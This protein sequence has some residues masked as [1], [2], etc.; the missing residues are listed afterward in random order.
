MIK[1]LF[2]IFLL[3]LLL[4]HIDL[5][6]PKTKVEYPYP[7]TTNNTFSTCCNCPYC[8]S[9]RG[10]FLSACSCHERT[11]GS[12][13][14]VPLIKSALCFCG[15]SNSDFDLPGAKYPVLLSEILFVPPVLEIHSFLLVDSISPT[16][17]YLTLPDH[18]T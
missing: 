18:P 11:E 3:I 8:V 2:F 5:V 7:V 12:L 17:I 13:G 10:G 14:D 6:I 4:F 16:E 15:S 1:K 9:Q